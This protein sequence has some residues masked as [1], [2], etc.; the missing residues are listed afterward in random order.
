MTLVM[1]LRMVIIIIKM[2]LRGVLL[3]V[4]VQKTK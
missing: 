3:L 4:P 2:E 1:V